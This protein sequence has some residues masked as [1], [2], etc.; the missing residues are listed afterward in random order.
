MDVAKVI[1]TSTWIAN[2]QFS[3]FRYAT[4]TPLPTTIISP[5]YIRSEPWRILNVSS[6]PRMQNQH[7]QATHVVVDAITKAALPQ[8]V[9]R[10]ETVGDWP[11]QHSEVLHEH[12]MVVDWVESKC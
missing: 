10:Q 12:L 5:V 3:T 9:V 11:Y 1:H 7:T 6:T 4:P 2:S 8:L